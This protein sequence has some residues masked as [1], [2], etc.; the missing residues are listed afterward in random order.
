MPDDR[1]LLPAE[2]R[3]S[4]GW[5]TALTETLRADDVAALTEALDRT[6]RETVIA[7]ESFAAFDARL[8][9]LAG[10]AFA[11]FNAGRSF[12]ERL[13]TALRL[14]L[15]EHAQTASEQIGELQRALL[16]QAEGSV[17]AAM[18]GYADERPAAAISCAHWLLGHFW[19]LTRDQERLSAGAARASVLPLGSGL[20]AGA[21]GAIDREALARTLGFAR[22]SE[23][24]VDAV[25]D[26]DFAIEY[27]S[28]ANL[29]GVHLE[30]LASDL[31]HYSSSALGFVTMPADH[32][33]ALIA[34]RG[35]AAA[36]FGALAGFTSAYRAVGSGYHSQIGQNR[37]LIYAAAD[38]L[39]ASVSG[40]QDAVG[41]VTIEPD[42][43][44]EALDDRA[45]AADLV[46]YLAER[47]EADGAAIVRKLVVRAESLGVALSELPLEAYQA[48]SGRF[49]EDVF[50][51]FDATASIGRRTAAGGTAPAAIRAQIRQAATWL[52]DFEF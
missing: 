18:P 35:N 16:R 28:V 22:I 52:A 8:S 1:R 9:A 31:L 3:I 48:E 37:E 6:E 23:N 24:S 20:N 25:S 27:L 29:L 33:A 41:A 14:W 50:A 42:R 45:F 7:P 32:E 26:W 49:A 12:G 36:L 11:R 43:M 15:N 10:D 44:W 30:R 4:R 38:A 21:T 47:G 19:A 5:L 2:L 34:V 46:S 13:L 39:A 40:L 51:L 17:G